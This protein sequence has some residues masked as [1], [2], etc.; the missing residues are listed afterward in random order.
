[1]EE[2]RRLYNENTFNGAQSWLHIRVR[3]QPLA[4]YTMVIEEMA[5]VISL[6]AEEFVC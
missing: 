6:L 2:E 4:R 5:Y 3:P 1:M